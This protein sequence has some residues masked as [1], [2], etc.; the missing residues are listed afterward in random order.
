MYHPQ[1]ELLMAHETR[2]LDAGQP[3]LTASAGVAT[4]PSELS[5][6]L[7]HSLDAAAAVAPQPTIDY[8]FGGAADP[9]QPAVQYEPLAAGH[10]HTMNM[11]RDYCNGHYTA[12]AEPFLRGARTGA[13]VFGAT[14]DES[15]AYMPMPFESSPP[16][17]ATSGRKRSRA[18]LGGGFHGGPAGGVEKK[19]KQR[20]QRLTEK[21]NA[22]M[23]LIPNRTKD[24]RATVISDA[25]EYIQELGRTVE[26]LTLLVE[27]KRRRMELQG[28]VVDAAPAVAVAAAAA[29]EAE[30]SEG[31]V[32][33][34]PPAVQRQPIRSTYIQRRSK[35]TSVDVRIVEED[36][37]IKLTKRRRDGCL[38]AASRALDDLRLELVHLSGGKIGDCHIYMFNTKI[39]PSSPVFASAVASRLMEVV[40][41]Y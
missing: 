16:P 15:A 1:C 10:Q 4:I 24:D 40:D 37:N 26:E 5:F 22:L 18:L 12:A 31:E 14:D 2:D 23:L 7:L 17:R 25:I 34:P 41:D 19:E 28:D 11:L 29:G 33:P 27:K 9:H 36:V 8:F 39:H 30:S 13:L 3:H 21:Y 38:A 20:R 32:A 35:D 6:H